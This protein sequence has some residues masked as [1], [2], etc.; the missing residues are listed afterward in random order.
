MLR[1]IVSNE[2]LTEA[3]ATHPLQSLLLVE[4]KITP[5]ATAGDGSGNPGAIILCR[6][7]QP[8]LDFK[9]T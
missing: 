8:A 3:V 6:L 7:G 4:T 1:D 9:K 2:T 5:Q